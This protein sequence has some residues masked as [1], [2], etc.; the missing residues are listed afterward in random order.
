MR[1]VV[2]GSTGAGTY[3]WTVDQDCVLL[4]V[5]SAVGPVTISENPNMV[6]NDF[7]SGFSGT[8][9][10]LIAIQLGSTL[11]GTKRTVTLNIPLS[12]D[13]TIYAGFAGIG[14]AVLILDSVPTV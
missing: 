6:P 7:L 10:D 8:R 14:A 4:D 11:T 5:Q 9:F 2:I 3:A 12:K 1:S 13:R